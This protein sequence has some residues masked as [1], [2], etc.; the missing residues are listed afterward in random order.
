MTKQEQ[1]IIRNI[2][3]D[4]LFWIVRGLRAKR[5]SQDYVK[6]L[7]AVTL[8]ATKK[9]TVAECLNTLFEASEKFWEANN[10]FVKNARE[11]YLLVD[12][13]KL[14]K[15]RAKLSEKDIDGAVFILK[16]GEN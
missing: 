7:A 15:G 1:K 3:K 8:A 5:T 4:T 2:Q 13:G 6:E 9:T 14:I 11:Y 10:V 16:G 12:Q